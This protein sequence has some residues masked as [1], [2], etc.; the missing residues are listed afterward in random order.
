MSE[1]Y[2][3][4]KE[5]VKEYIAAAEGFD[6]AKLIR[7]MSEHL[8]NGASVLELGSGP[9]TDWSLL[10]KKYNVTGSDYS[11]EFVNYLKTKFPEGNFISVNAATMEVDQK[12]DAIYSN[13]VLHHL[14]H[15]E[16]ENCIQKQAELLTVNGLVCHS[17]W[18]GEGDEMF[19][20]MYV[21]Y[22]SKKSIKLLFSRYFDVI[23]LSEYEEFEKEDSV[24][25]MAKKKEA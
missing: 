6:G 18:K 23:T 14:T 2:Y 22:H 21:N 3:H 12:F 16:L 5:S 9:G 1:K 13:K 19:K 7:E 11:A 17:F 25:L 4:T 15:E 10:S 24:F 20:G 8:P